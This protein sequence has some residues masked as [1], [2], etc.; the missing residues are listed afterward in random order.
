MMEAAFFAAFVLGIFASVHCVGMCGP[1]AL[2]LPMA[3]GGRAAQLAHLLK[4]HAGRICTYALGGLLFG[5]LGRR[6]WIAGWQQGLSIGLGVLILVIS[7]VRRWLPVYVRS[8]DP[9][10]RVVTR[11]WQLSARKG[12]FILGMANG[13]LPCG[14]VYLAIAGALTLPNIPGSMGF[15]A[16]FGFGTLPLLLGLQWAGRML[17]LS[18]R[19]RLRRVLPLVTIVMAILLILRGLNLG[20]PYISPMLSSAAGTA[21]S[22][23]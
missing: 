14:M 20:I 2:G 7:L 17:P 5:W 13:F 23:H 9:L 15:M 21:I 19:L 16:A 6:V 8:Y 10:R 1:L 3:H 12:V 18:Y 22:C 11:I 4:Y